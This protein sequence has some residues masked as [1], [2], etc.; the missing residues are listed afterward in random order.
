MVLWATSMA[1]AKLQ[2]AM[3]GSPMKVGAK[4]LGVQLSPGQTPTTISP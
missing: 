2:F 1:V 4:H 3:L